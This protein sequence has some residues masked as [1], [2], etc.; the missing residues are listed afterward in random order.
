MEK[1]RVFIFA[2][3]TN[4]KAVGGLTSLLNDHIDKKN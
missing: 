3:R 4:P 2:N 1:G